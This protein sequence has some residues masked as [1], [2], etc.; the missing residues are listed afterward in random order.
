[1]AKQS[2]IIPVPQWWQLPFALALAWQGKSAIFGSNC[3]LCRERPIMRMDA[4]L[5]TIG[6]NPHWFNRLGYLC[7]S[8]H[9]SSAWQVPRFQLSLDLPNANIITIKGM[10][11]VPYQFPYDSVMRKFKNSHQF[12]QLTILVHV[13]RQLDKPAG[14]H[15]DNSVIIPVPSSLTRLKERGFEPLWWLAQYLSFHWQIPIFAGI[16][17]QERAHQQ[18]LGRE[19]RLENVKGAFSVEQLPPVENIILFDDVVTT[20]ATL[21][22][23][24][25]ALYKNKSTLVK[26][27]AIVILHGK[28]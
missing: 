25:Y 20:G 9:D 1:M 21:S 22:E 6:A 28:F 8:C 18:G 16:T 11:S 19:A 15:A 2:T 27:N 10:A 14:C 17:R 5:A 26:I 3:H 24:V 7:Q 13:L 4:P 12:N 23:L